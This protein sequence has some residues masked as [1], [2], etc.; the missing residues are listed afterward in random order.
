MLFG[1]LDSS[2][3]S[4][5]D[6]NSRNLPTDV[7]NGSPLTVFI[8]VRGWVVVFEED[9]VLEVV[10]VVQ[11]VQLRV[12]PLAQFVD[13]GGYRAVGNVSHSPPCVHMWVAKIV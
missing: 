7:K 11:V 10:E 9:V 5:F 12:G 13:L 1:F 8:V 2:L 3:S 4:S 6:A